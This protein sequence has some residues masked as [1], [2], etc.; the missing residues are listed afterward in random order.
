MFCLC[1]EFVTY[2][3]NMVNILTAFC[4][5]NP[6]RLFGRVEIATP[7]CLESGYATFH[8]FHETVS[9][10]YKKL[11]CHDLNYCE[12][13]PILHLAE[14]YSCAHIF[15]NMSFYPKMFIVLILDIFKTVKILLLNNE[16]NNRNTTI[17]SFNFIL[18]S[19]TI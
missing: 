7:S 16:I 18:L 2:F 6:N 14:E 4:K 19:F 5:K 3:V 1:G 13:M 10:I 15:Q 12:H 11:F 8:S 17:L 9:Y